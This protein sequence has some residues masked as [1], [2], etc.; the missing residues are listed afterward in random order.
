MR[1]TQP[2]S[3]SDLCHVLAWILVFHGTACD[4]R[5]KAP[6]H[7]AST[8][9]HPTVSIEQGHGIRRSI[10]QWRPLIAPTESFSPNRLPLG[11]TLAVAPSS[12][13]DVRPIVERHPRFCTPTTGRVDSMPLGVGVVRMIEQRPIDTR[14][15]AAVHLELG[16]D[17]V[18]MILD[19][20]DFDDQGVG[21]L[22]VAAAGRH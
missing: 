6:G 5:F 10:S 21:D 7:T 18:H 12:W 11:A 8:L 9:Y 15:M 2:P 14:I 17:I 20:A 19:R 4:L 1:D 3:V 22:L 13:R 16:E